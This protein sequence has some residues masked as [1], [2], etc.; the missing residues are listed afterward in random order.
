MIK[1]QDTI[2]KSLMIG[3]NWKGNI[4]YLLEIYASDGIYHCYECRLNE[5]TCKSMIKDCN[6][7]NIK[8][9]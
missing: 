9:Q 2:T 6:K 8:Q 5:A 1:L 4:I 7:D 3:N